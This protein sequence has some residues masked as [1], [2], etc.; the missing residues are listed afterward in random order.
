MDADMDTGMDTDMDLVMDSNMDADV[1]AGIVAN[2]ERTYYPPPESKGGWRYLIEP[3]KIRGIAGM[4]HEKLEIL[5]EKIGFIH[6]GCAWSVAVIRH[7]YLACEF[8]SFGATIATRYLVCSVSKSFTGT[9]WGLLLDDSR[10]GAIPVNKAVDLESRA[11]DYLPEGYPLTDPRKKNIRIKHLL[12]MTSGIPGEDAG[13]WGIATATGYGPFEHSLGRY[14]SK[15]G[16][17]VDMLAAEPGTV[18]DYSDPAFAHLSLIFNNITGREM[19]DYIMERIFN[20]I[21]IESVSWGNMGGSGFLGPHTEPHTGVY[22]SARELARFGY[23]ALHNGQWDGRQIIPRWWNEL[24]TRSSQE[25]NPDYGYTWWANT[26]GTLWPYLPRDAFAAMGYN[27]NK[28]YVIPSLDLVVARTGLGPATSFEPDL[29][30][31][32]VKTIIA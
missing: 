4:N 6:A 29:I 27:S 1:D 32:I 15:R 22:I 23:L 21:G 30:G 17:R 25:L 2:L 3:E 12:S 5:K 18:W 16:K 20:K 24:A 14:P 31:G 10:N 11:Y 9:A 26:A 13:I 28:C 8:H 19:S 7:G